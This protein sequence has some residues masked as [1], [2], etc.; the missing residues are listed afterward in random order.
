MT[1]FTKE[2]GSAKITVKR[3]TNRDR[4]NRDA[5]YIAVGIA[6]STQIR[7]RQEEFAELVAYTTAIEGFD[8]KIPSPLSPRDEIKDA[9]EKFMDL[10]AGLT[11]AWIDAVQTVT[12]PIDFATGP[13]P[14]GEGSDPN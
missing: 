5:V 11:E 9:F 8:F 2:F 7:L 12:R 1:S 6:P 10:D 3:P 14:L 4:A 13:K